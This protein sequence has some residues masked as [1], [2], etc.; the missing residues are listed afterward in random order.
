MFT[1][2]ERNH[3][4]T[5]GGMGVVK[6][7]GSSSQTPWWAWLLLVGV[8]GGLAVFFWKVLMPTEAPSWKSPGFWDIFI[9]SRFMIGLGRLSALVVGLTL[10]VYLVISMIALM[11]SGRWLSSV[12]LFRADATRQGVESATQDRDKLVDQLSAA[13]ETITKQEQ[14]IQDLR[15]GLQEALDLVRGV[16]R[17]VY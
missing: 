1:S 5:V 15:S 4:A 14:A 12:G 7:A 17:G 13:Q 16:S 3:W 2:D 11:R 10:V 6:P 8:V 9:S